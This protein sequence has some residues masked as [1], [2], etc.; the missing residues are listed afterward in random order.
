MAAALGGGKGS[1]SGMT[2]CVR[3]CVRL[4]VWLKIVS[5][6]DFNSRQSVLLSAAEQ[7][8]PCLL[9]PDFRCQ[10][11]TAVLSGKHTIQNYPEH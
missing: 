8:P 2:V 3:A 11:D 5:D 6:G 4:C 1:V 9:S 7:K 10:C